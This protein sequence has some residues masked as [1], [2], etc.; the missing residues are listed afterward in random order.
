VRLAAQTYNI[1][2]QVGTWC[3]VKRRNKLLD[4]VSE[5]QSLFSTI[6]SHPVARCLL[7]AQDGDMV[8]FEANIVIGF[9]M[10]G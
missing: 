8:V 1:P 4:L 5:H 2:Q 7:P 9:S 10:R 3:V 6:S